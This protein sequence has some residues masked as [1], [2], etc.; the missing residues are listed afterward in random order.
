MNE[1]DRE[2]LYH[3]AHKLWG[4]P[5]QMFMVMEEMSELQKE[6][7]KQMRGEDRTPQIIEEIADVEIMLE[8]LQHISMI[9]REAIEKVKLEKLKRLEKLIK[10][11]EES[12]QE[13]DRGNKNG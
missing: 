9:P 13:Q 3:R 2:D 8:Q 4:T 7:C 10:G 12:L 1:L 6:I 11:H 5:A